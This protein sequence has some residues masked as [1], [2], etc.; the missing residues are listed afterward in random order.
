L[1]LA[2]HRNLLAGDTPAVAL[3][4]AQARTPV[5]GFVCLGSG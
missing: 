4:R 2:F 1:M 3:A 5:A